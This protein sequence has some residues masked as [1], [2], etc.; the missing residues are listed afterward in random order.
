MRYNKY[1]KPTVELL[2]SLLSK[3]YDLNDDLDKMLLQIMNEVGAELISRLR[4]LESRGKINLNEKIDIYH[5]PEIFY[6][7]Y[8]LERGIN[9]RL[10]NY[11]DILVVAMTSTLIETYKITV[12]STY[13]IFSEVKKY[14]YPKVVITDNHIKNQVLN[15]PWCQDGKTYSQRIYSNVANFE[16]KLAYV[17]EQGITNGKGLDWMTQAWRKLTGSSAY[18]TARLLK[19]ET[20][21]MWSQATKATY[22]SLGIEYVEITGDAE[23]GGICLDYVGEAIPL[24]DAELGDLLPPY[25]PNCACSYVAYTEDVP[26]EEANEEDFYEVMGEEY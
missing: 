24:R 20:V 6:E 12:N 13:N 14:P 7:M 17:L 23:C 4:E 22:L 3:A 21:A 26:I 15:I 18:D 16:S 9:K 10:N 8:E 2:L 11:A 5:N 19:T 1:R 25:H